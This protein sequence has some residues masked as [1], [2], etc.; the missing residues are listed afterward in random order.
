[1]SQEEVLSLAKKYEAGS[2]VR[3]LVQSFGIDRTTVLAHLERQGVGRRRQLRKMTDADVAKAAGLY[4]TGE[5]LKAT[6]ARL[7]VNAETLRR[8]FTKAG[9]PVR[10]RRG[11]T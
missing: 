6:G 10:P 4:A 7:G 5:S 1:L 2:T 8:E 3:D 11:W 9:I